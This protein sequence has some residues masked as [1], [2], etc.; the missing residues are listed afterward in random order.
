MIKKI[1][2][3]LS[4]IAVVAAVVVGATTAY[5]SD[6]ETSTGNTLTAGTIDLAVNDMN[7]F[8]GT[9]VTIKDVKPSKEIADRL[10]RL[11]N[12]GTNDGIANLH[13]GRGTHSEG[14]DSE[15][16]CQAEGAIHGWIP[17]H[18]RC[19]RSVSAMDENICHV[20]IYD[21]CY[22]AND[23]KVCDTGERHLISPSTHIDL[24]LLPAGKERI[25]WLSHHLAGHAGNEYQGDTCTWDIDFTLK[26]VRP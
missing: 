5:F 16:E 15:P 23:N 19:D 3:S 7:P 10:V 26:Q 20:I 11:Q 8:H 12:V 6:V 22:D 4:V 13:I 21:Y 24:G 1:L 2:I 14:I 25:L 17:Q 18:G 9:V